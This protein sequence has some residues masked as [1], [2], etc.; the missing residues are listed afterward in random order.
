MVDCD[1]PTLKPVTLVAAKTFNSA[2]PKGADFFE[3]KSVTGQRIIYYYGR[4][5]DEID[6][7]SLR[8]ARNARSVEKSD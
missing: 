3:L 5:V 4:D 7:K 8:S 6:F 2:Y 1:S